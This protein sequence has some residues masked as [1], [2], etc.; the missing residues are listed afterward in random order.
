MMESHGKLESQETSFMMSM[1]SRAILQD[2]S[3]GPDRPNC[4]RKVF[5]PASNGTQ[6]IRLQ[7]SS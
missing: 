1:C 7:N 4:M 2:P 3:P 5:T 6:A